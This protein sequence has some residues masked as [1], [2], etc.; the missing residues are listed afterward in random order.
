MGLD[1]A[2]N[3]RPAAVSANHTIVRLSEWRSSLAQATASVVYSCRTNFLLS[4]E[5]NFVRAGA[6][7]E[8]ELVDEPDD[9]NWHEYSGP[10]AVD[11]MPEESR[12]LDRR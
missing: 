11:T 5:F 6:V 12:L 7:Q 9:E 2:A 8:P 3:Q 4:V 10:A 1:R